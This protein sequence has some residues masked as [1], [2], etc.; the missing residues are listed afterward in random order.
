MANP[1]TPSPRRDD[2]GIL[3]EVITTAAEIVHALTKSVFGLSTDVREA[4]F[5]TTRGTLDWVDGSLR[6]AVGFAQNA[7]GRVETLIQET[8]DSVERSILS[9]IDRGRE[10]GHGAADLAARTA[11]SFTGRSEP[12]EA[13]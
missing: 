2:D 4:V 6:S 5:G 1:S 13:A 3:A 12:R 7:T 8:S 11:V 9:T 10:T